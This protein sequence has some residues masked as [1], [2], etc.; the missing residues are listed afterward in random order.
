LRTKRDLSII[1][2]GY[3]FPHKKIYDFL[4]VLNKEGFKSIDV[5]AATWVELKSNNTA[6]KND[7]VVYDI[8]NICY[9]LGLNYHECKHEDIQ[10]IEIIKNKSG[11]EL[12]IISGARIIKSNIIELFKDGIVNFHTGKIPETSGLDSFYYSIKNNC[13]MGVTAHL[14]D[15]RVDAGRF[16]FFDQVEVK[17]DNKVEDLKE[18]IYIAQLKALSRYLRD[19]LQQET[20]FNK[21]DRPHKN[22]SLSLAEKKNIILGFEEWKENQINLQ[23]SI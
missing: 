14:I 1:V 9:L 2:F 7:D 18:N 21:I 5:I 4:K 3:A 15:E 6:Y 22:I 17:I 10:K 20:K 16:I 8:K 19:Y 23:N 12:G 13:P 11:A